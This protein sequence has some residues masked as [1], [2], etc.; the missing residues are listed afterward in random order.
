M[1]AM[2]II[3]L[4]TIAVAIAFLLTRKNYSNYTVKLDCFICF[5]TDAFPRRTF[6]TVFLHKKFNMERE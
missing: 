1:L 6:I 5:F 3:L 2:K 4:E